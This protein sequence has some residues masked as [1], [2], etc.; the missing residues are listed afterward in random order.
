V[1][2]TEIPAAAGG[3]VT[4]IVAGTNVTVSGATG[5]VTVNAASQFGTDTTLQ[6]ADATAVL[7]NSLELI[8][9]LTVTTHSA[10]TSQW[11]VKL[12]SAG[13]FGT[14]LTLN[15]SALTLASAQI[16]NAVGSQ[17][18]PAY[19]FTTDTAMGMYR[20]GSA[21]LGFAMG[22][23]VA[24]S[25]Q[26]SL[27]AIT[28]SAAQLGFGSGGVNIQASGNVSLVTTV[29]AAGQFNVVTDG[30]TSFIVN[31]DGNVLLGPLSAIATNATQGWP[32]MRA[33]AG[34]PTGV[35]GTIV[36]GMNQFQYDETNHKFWVYDRGAS[37]WKGIALL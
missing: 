36:T 18:A 35:P 10:T 37:A 3:A 4:S 9:T 22:G 2:Y 20:V 13:T 26:P 14:Y 25:I 28:G 8:N 12:M 15:P 23:T 33:S 29:G 7:V 5:D 1:V 11:A 17:A 6:L 19:S 24:V 21:N 16:F 31:K 32:Y 27:L 34:A 30:G